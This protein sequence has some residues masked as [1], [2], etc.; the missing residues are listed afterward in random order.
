MVVVLARGTGG[1]GGAGIT[2]VPGGG[3][4]PGVELRESRAR[5]QDGAG[6]TGQKMLA[7][8]CPILPLAMH[9]K[10]LAPLTSSLQRAGDLGFDAVLCFDH[11]PD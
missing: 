4:G 1:G 10:P 7:H 9:V 8:S 2:T 6:H 11:Y 3:G 5:N